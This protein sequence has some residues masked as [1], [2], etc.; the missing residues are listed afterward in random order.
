M[1][2]ARATESSPADEAWEILRGLLAAGR[3]RF[4]VAASELDLHPA[5]AG[6]LLHLEPATPMPMHELATVLGCDN[7]NVTGIV[8]RL[9]ARGLVTRRPYAQDR[10]VKHVV[11]SPAG[12]ELR[13]RV[14]AHM[15]DAP[16]AIRRLS[17]ADQCLLRDVLRRAVEGDQAPAG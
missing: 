11:L 4:L 13:D 3:R 15:A 16:E 8:D 7:S 6:A 9:E 2:L 17:E 12:V 1:A 5:Q 10:R 14:R